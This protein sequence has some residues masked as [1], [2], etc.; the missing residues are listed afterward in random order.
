VGRDK[1]IRI[2]ALNLTVPPGAVYARVENG[3]FA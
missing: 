3:W 1:I 2:A